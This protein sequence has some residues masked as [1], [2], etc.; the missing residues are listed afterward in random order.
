MKVILKN[1]ACTNN[2]LM[3]VILLLISTG[4]TAKAQNGIAGKDTAALKIKS[5]T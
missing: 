2:L 3:C 5:Y 1:I 4:Y